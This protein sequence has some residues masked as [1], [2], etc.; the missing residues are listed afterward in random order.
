MQKMIMVKNIL[1]SPCRNTKLYPLDQKRVTALVESFGRTGW[2]ENV[3]GRMRKDGKVELAYGEY[4][5]NAL[6][7]VKKPTDKVGI[8]ILPLTE[9]DMTRMFADENRAE[10]NH[11]STTEQ[12]VVRSV[13]ERYAKGII[14]LPKPPKNT[15]G[16]H[17]R[18][19]P[20]FSKGGKGAPKEGRQSSRSGGSYTALTIAEYLGWTVDSGKG[21]GKKR[22]S[23]R[24]V[25]A[26][27]ILSMAEDLGAEPDGEDSVS[28]TVAKMTEGVGTYSA[29]E[30]LRN[31][32]VLEHQHEKNG[33]SKKEAKETA[34]DAGKELGRRMRIDGVDK[35]GYRN[36]SKEARDFAPKP[37]GQEEL[38]DINRFIEG[39]L[40]DLGKILRQGNL[41]KGLEDLT[42]HREYINSR[43]QTRIIEGLGRL[44]KRCDTQIAKFQV[45][46]IG[47]KSKLLNKE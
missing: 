22:A 32:K 37:T 11:D 23:E 36:V 1:P 7:R 41:L 19:A 25:N 47:S 33:K 31:V 3:V 40:G 20:Y 43:Q 4:R 24:L 8:N 16:K 6:L 21:K 35:L 28:V 44:K 38:P 39:F 5:R 9:D 10:Y 15:D 26:L 17:L 2:W 45:K 18:Y 12:E 29:R 34:M 30:L 27:E 46:K 14:K 13:V 42:D